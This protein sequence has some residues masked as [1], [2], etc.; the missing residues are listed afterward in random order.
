M[1]QSLAQ[2]STLRT[3]SQVSGASF[4]L[5]EEISLFRLVAWALSGWSLGPRVP[6]WTLTPS[7]PTYLHCGPTSFVPNTGGVSAVCLEI[8]VLPLS[9]ADVKSTHL[10]KTS[11]RGGRGSTSALTQRRLWRLFI[12]SSLIYAETHAGWSAAC[13]KSTLNKL[14][15]SC[16]DKSRCLFVL[17]FGFFI[18]FFLFKREREDF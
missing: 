16:E 15:I 13:T 6:L 11:L 8:K 9:G 10:T 4:P 2:T 5:I 3:W 7:L 12:H 17:C 14:Q 18:S 1:N